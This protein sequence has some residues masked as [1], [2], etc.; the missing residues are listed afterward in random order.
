[1][2]KPSFRRLQRSRSLSRSD[3]FVVPSGTYIISFGAGATW[4][5]AAVT[6]Y[7]SSGHD[8]PQAGKRLEFC[9][10]GRTVEIRDKRGEIR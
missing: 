9:F 2:R 10:A 6:P 8:C 1:M 4:R 5:E 7:C 3:I